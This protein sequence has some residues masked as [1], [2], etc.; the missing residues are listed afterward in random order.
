MAAAA[1]KKKKP[2]G[3][4]RH[5]TSRS[6]RVEDEL[7]AE[8]ERFAKETGQPFTDL[9]EYGLQ[10]ALAT[11]AKEEPLTRYV[12]FLMWQTTAEELRM[13]RRLVGLMRMTMNSDPWRERWRKGVLE[14]LEDIEKLPEFEEAL[15]SC[16]EPPPLA[17]LEAEKKTKNEQ[18]RT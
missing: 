16:G 14:G 13:I 7:L 18:A 17:R 9:V 10:L 12:N 3:F 5:K 2:R 11:R 1:P 15:A 8:A 4:E 6:I